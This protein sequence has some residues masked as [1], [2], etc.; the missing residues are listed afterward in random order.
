M[1]RSGCFNAHPG[2]SRS[3]TPLGRPMPT[4]ALRF[5]A[6][7]AEAGVQRAMGKASKHKIQ[8]QRSPR[9]KPGV[10]PSPLHHHRRRRGVSTRTPAKSG[11]QLAQPWIGDRVEVV[12]TLTPAEAGVQLSE[13][14]PGVTSHKFQRSPRP[15]PGCNRAL[16]RYQ[17]GCVKVS[18]LTP[19]EAGVQPGHRPRR[20]PGAPVSTLTLAEAG[21]QPRKDRAPRLTA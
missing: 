11:V 5:N 1:A 2:F 10:Q 8:F 3:A 6:H 20:L 12:S 15:K 17:G 16:A 14:T 18:T 4:R 21:V 7:P 9:P 19:A 13:V